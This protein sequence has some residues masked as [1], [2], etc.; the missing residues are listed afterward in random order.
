MRF[1]KVKARAKVNLTLDITGR[2]GKYHLLD[3]LMLPIDL[4]DLVYVTKRKDGLI[5]LTSRGMG[6]ENI[7]ETENNAYKAA[8]LFRDRFATGG[9]DISVYKNIPTGAGLGGSSADA[10]GVLTALQRL[11]L[12]SADAAQKAQI[13]EIADATGS[14]TRSMYLGGAVR[15]RG[16]GD[17]AERLFPTEN[18]YRKSGAKKLYFLLVCPQTAVST[19][20][21]FALYDEENAATS[22]V[23]ERAVRAY[24]EGDTATLFGCMKND[25][26]RAACRLNADV[27][28]ALREVAAFSPD[29]YGV[30]GSGSAVFAVFETKEL[31]D[32][33]KSR[34]K[35][36]FRTI[37][38]ESVESD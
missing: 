36:R 28:E 30:S 24:A 16:R 25:L 32:W 1:C 9:A 10:A 17:I 29:G 3:S 8:V 13:A 23:T 5:R 19:P 11:Y 18:D 31:R 38:A 22:P 27:A 33:A 35:G 26:A 20:S 37:A 15:M 12:P 14:D 34:Y 2:E 4:H 6:S 7:P 21:C